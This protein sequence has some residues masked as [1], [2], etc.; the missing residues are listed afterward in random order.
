V[1]YAFIYKALIDGTDMI[2]KVSIPS[3]FVTF[4]AITFSLAI[5]NNVFASTV[6]A[7]EQYSFVTSLDSPDSAAYVYV[8]DRARV[9]DSNRVQ[10]FTSNGTLITTWGTTGANAGQFNNPIGIA[11]DSSGNVYVADTENNRVQK[12]TSNG[13]LI[14]KWGA[15]GP[16]AGQFNNPI[17][18][19][20]DSSGNVYV[21][22]TENNRVQKFTSNGTLI[23]KWG[24]PGPN[25]GQFN[26]PTALTVDSSG[27]VYVI[28]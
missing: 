8:G 18:I 16:N 12:F 20:V 10:K 5:T 21:A 13:T 17:G 23:T 9:A 4:L 22:D 7:Q 2:R 6:H 3:N 27:N 28:D 25:A 19:A 14:T 24:A 1:S 26:N 11:V 15:P